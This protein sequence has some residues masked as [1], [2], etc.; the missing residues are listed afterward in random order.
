MVLY[1]YRFQ[2]NIL[3]AAEYVCHVPGAGV[4]VPVED[5]DQGLHLG[6]TLNTVSN[7]HCSDVH[8]HLAL[9]VLSMLPSA[10]GKIQP[11]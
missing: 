11:V 9:S 10:P 4:A 8:L 2:V 1:K 3:T 7:N 5:K 6:P